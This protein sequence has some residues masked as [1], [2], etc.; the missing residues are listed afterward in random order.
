MNIF[1]ARN[2]NKSLLLSQ[3]KTAPIELLGDMI[4][5]PLALVGGNWKTAAK[6]FQD[7]AEHVLPLRT[8]PG[9]GPI[10][11]GILKHKPYLQPQQHV[12]YGY[13]R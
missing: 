5:T 7:A 13:G 8:L 3:I 11:D 1:D 12:I 2:Q 9:I 10:M 4:S 6:D